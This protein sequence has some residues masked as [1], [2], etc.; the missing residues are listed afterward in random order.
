M[1]EHALNLAVAG[2]A[3]LMSFLGLTVGLICG[4][5][6]ADTKIAPPVIILW[7]LATVVFLVVSVVSIIGGYT[8]GVSQ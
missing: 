1:N 6:V 8:A 2:P 5:G 7:A 3:F 4:F